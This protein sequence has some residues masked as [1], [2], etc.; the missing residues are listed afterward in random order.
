MPLALL[1]QVSWVMTAS[2]LPTDTRPPCR[3][4]GSQ[5][6]RLRVILR[7]AT[8]DAGPRS[9]DHEATWLMGHTGRITF[10]SDLWEDED[11]LYVSAE[12]HI[13]CRFLS[14]AGGIAECGAYGYT[15]KA[16]EP[17]SR[18]PAPRRLGGDRFRIV[19]RGRLASRELRTPP[20]PPR[21]LPVRMETNPCVGA[22]CRT[23]DNQRGAACCRDLQVEI[24]CTT[25]ERRLE[26]LIRARKRPYLCKVER[27]GKYSL[28]A[29]MISACGFLGDDG[30]SCALHGRSRADGRSAKP[31]LCSDWP[32]GGE[33]LH[34][35]CVF[36]PR[37][38][39]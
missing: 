11:D 15:G 9:G 33:T 17:V 23:A 20:P 13:P 5:C 29:E 4:M 22:P 37:T 39:Q 21:S 10:L 31:D 36:A 38:G 8:L 27:E 26:S 35:G 7:V 16:A 3:S 19:E 25:R 2:L 12:L 24:M 28:N 18:V 30:V 32:E 14:E 34:P 1:R 6:H